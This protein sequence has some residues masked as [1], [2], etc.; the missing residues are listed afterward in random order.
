MFKLK[1]SLCSEAESEVA[2]ASS[3]TGSLLETQETVAVEES[4]TTEETTTGEETQTAE[5]PE[6][7]SEEFDSPESLAK[8]HAELKE[9]LGVFAGAPEEY[10]LNEYEDFKFY[11]GTDTDVANFMV[12]A[13]EMGISQEGF[14]K[15]MDSYVSSEMQRAN[16]D[17]KARN[18]IALNDLGGEKVGRERINTLVQRAKTSMDESQFQLFK[19]ATS[20]G[21]NSVSATIRLVESLLGKEASP[22]G[23]QTV[24]T[25]NVIPK[26]ELLDMMKDPKYKT[27]PEFRERVQNGFKLLHGEV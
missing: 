23:T 27:S 20:A 2:S 11:E 21:Q 8:S 22:M 5:R 9:K 7:L 17:M 24:K 18:D 15:L 6:W 14:T 10:T 16:I 13:K 3:S 4:V 25:Q 19:E 1:N 26:D 12:L